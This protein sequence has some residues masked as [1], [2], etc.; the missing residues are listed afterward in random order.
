MGGLQE[1]ILRLLLEAEDK[2]KPGLDQLNGN[3]QKTEQRVN[4]GKAAFGALTGAVGSSFGGAL[5]DAARAAADEEVNIARLQTSLAATTDAGDRWNTAVD[6]M[7]DRAQSLSFS[8]DQA[9]GGLAVLAQETGS[10]EEALKRLPIAMDLARAKHIDLE[11]A[12]RLLGRVNEENTKVLTRLGVVIDKGATSFDVLTKVQQI[13]A[14]QSEA[15]ANTTRGFL[16]RM[17]IGWDNLKENIGNALGP[18]QGVIALMPGFSA[19]FTA[20]GAVLG[21][22]SAKEGESTAAQIA[23]SVATTATTI[24]TKAFAIA[25]GALNLVLSANPIGIVILALAG[26]ALA[27]KFAY[28]H[29]EAFRNV[30]QALFTWLGNLLGPL[31][32]VWDTLSGFARSL[33]LLGPDSKQ[34]QADVSSSFGAMASDSNAAMSSMGS[35]LDTTRSKMAAMTYNV[36]SLVARFNQLRLAQSGISTSGGGPNENLGNVPSLSFDEGGVVPGPLGAPR[37]AIVHGGERVLTVDEQRSGSGG[38][39]TIGQ[40]VIYGNVDS[41][42]RVQEL[43]EAVGDYFRRRGIAAGASVSG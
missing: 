23:H 19:T 40:I 37:V 5:S 33:G 32:A 8:D 26:L 39:V 28:D 20:A 17:T 12:A 4:A 1:V 31:K 10:T 43:A 24:A 11:L 6:A 30:V 13:S 16:D 35:S 22:F 7:I 36:D 42:S 25:Q 29:S 38:G 34:T 14:G 3:L 18:L 27:I 2:T 15:Y 9:R 41:H 21:F